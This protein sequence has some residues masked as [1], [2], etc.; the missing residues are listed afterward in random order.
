M[1]LTLEARCRCIGLCR[2]NEPPAEL[3]GI[4]G[5]SLHGGGYWQ[6]RTWD[7]YGYGVEEGGLPEW[8]TAGFGRRV[9][10][11]D[12][13]GAATQAALGNGLTDVRSYSA[14][15]G[16]LTR[17][18]V[19]TP[20]SSCG[21][22]RQDYTY[23]GWSNLIS[24]SQ[25]GGAPA[26]SESFHYDALHRLTTATVSGHGQ[27]TYGYDGSG[28]L[29][30]KSDY[31]S[32][33]QYHPTKR[34]AVVSVQPPVGQVYTYTYDGNGNQL[35]QR[36]GTAVARLVRYDVHNRPIWL[37]P[38]AHWNYDPDDPQPDPTP[39][40]GDTSF[41]Y[42]PDGRRYLQRVVGA[43]TLDNFTVYPLE[44][45]EV[46]GRGRNGQ[47]TPPSCQPA[48]NC[49]PMA[50][51]KVRQALGDYGLR[52]VTV[53]QGIGV[54]VTLWQHRDR[55]GSAVAKTQHNGT[56]YSAALEGQSQAHPERHGFDAWGKPRRADWS[57]TP[58]AGPGGSGM[59]NS[60]VGPRG[61][62]DH[63]H[64]D[65]FRLIHMNGRAYDPLLGRFLSV[66]PIIQFPANSQSLNPYSYILNNP[67]AGT[68]PTG[69]ATSCGDVSA[70]D[71]GS[72]S[73][74][75]TLDNGK[76]VSVNYNVNGRGASVS[77]SG[78]TFN[79]IAADNGARLAQAAEG[80]GRA[81]G[82][83]SGIPSASGIGQFRMPVQTMQASGSIHA[84]NGDS[85]ANVVRGIDDLV[86][87][88]EDEELLIDLKGRFPD[89][90]ARTE[91]QIRILHN[92]SVTER[93]AEGCT[94]WSCSFTPAQIQ[95]TRIVFHHHNVAPAAGDP[96]GREW[97]SGADV[98]IARHGVV[99]ALYTPAG[100][101]RAVER[102]DGQ[103]RARTI[104]GGS[105]R[106]NRFIEGTWR[107]DM[108]DQEISNAANRYRR[109]ER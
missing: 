89:A 45:M 33:Y 16:S 106:L 54:G 81:D 9:T 61:F 14:F 18:C 109:M 32:N 40:N 92:G 38:G 69:Y 70:S 80:V 84:A 103:Y 35:N 93:T 26:A 79:A 29:S 51:L 28:N 102:I 76:A 55:L 94:S 50:V 88:K 107:P 95:Q 13:Y 17:L 105:S 23:N 96:M 46:E 82:S 31:G 19:G 44:G 108:T 36:W 56:V 98:N 83:M 60:S 77:A 73:C 20:G 11:L 27:V 58:G 59:L 72:G 86:L 91:S 74:E 100:A 30:S 65:R 41:R 5:G 63:E 97:P 8:N 57:A 64:L 87:S 37:R 67:L 15:T 90:N 24:Q 6:Y 48:T 21:I 62:T 53:N 39:V 78:S 3:G 99:N 71:K 75:H 12:A 49:A 2:E 4:I 34:H 42:T 66:D 7:R 43:S 25:S 22:V 1:I 68:D 85:E 104:W 47:Q 52:M 101:I 10:A